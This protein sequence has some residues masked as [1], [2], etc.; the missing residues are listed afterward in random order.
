MSRRKE[1]YS[2]KKYETHKLAE[3]ALG[4]MTKFD[5]LDVSKSHPMEIYKC[6]YCGNYH[7]G[8]R[9]GVIKDHMVKPKLTPKYKLPPELRKRL[10]TDDT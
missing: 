4:K 2:K 1:C 5:D 8:H 10:G 3:K 6:R 7:L 9:K